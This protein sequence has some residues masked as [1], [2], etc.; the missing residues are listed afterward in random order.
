MQVDVKEPLK[1]FSSMFDLDFEGTLVL[2]KLAS[3]GLVDK[4][5]EAVDQ[6]D[7]ARAAKLMKSAGVTQEEIAK[8]LEIMG[9]A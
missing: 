7:F 1:Y 8:V 6:D 2:E 3:H 5:Y 4:F 9:D